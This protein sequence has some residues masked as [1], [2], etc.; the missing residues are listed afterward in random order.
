MASSSASVVYPI[1][2]LPNK[3]DQGATGGD[4]IVTYHSDLAQCEI[5]PTGSRYTSAGNFKAGTFLPFIQP[6]FIHDLYPRPLSTEDEESS[7]LPVILSMFNTEP[8]ATTLEEDWEKK[9][10]TIAARL[11]PNKLAFEGV[12]VNGWETDDPQSVKVTLAMPRDSG[13]SARVSLTG[14]VDLDTFHLVDTAWP[15]PLTKAAVFVKLASY[16]QPEN[17]HPPHK[18]IHVCHVL[19]IFP[20]EQQ[21]WKSLA[22]WMRTAVNP[23]PRGSWIACN[24]RLL[25]VLD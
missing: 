23:F 25:G 19:L 18:G 6:T 22:G 17:D 2:P 5:L 24:G 15:E 13:T 3:R 12:A 1:P 14:P 11:F 9:W 21:P 7:G 8:K 10:F 20:V 4:L 16:L